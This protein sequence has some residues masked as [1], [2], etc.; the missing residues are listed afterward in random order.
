MNSSHQL[1]TPEIFQ[2]DSTEEF[3]NPNNIS[4]DRLNQG[5]R[6]A[7][8][9]LT[10]NTSSYRRSSIISIQRRGSIINYSNIERSRVEIPIDES[11]MNQEDFSPIQ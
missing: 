3:A 8:I 1:F 10:Q 11:Y 2:N 4:N 5:M 9:F 6:R 7:S